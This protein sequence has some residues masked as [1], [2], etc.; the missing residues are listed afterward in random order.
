MNMSNDNPNDELA[1][2]LRRE[3]M[4]ERPA[5]S[6]ELH[7][8]ILQQLDNEPQREGPSLSIKLALFAYAAGTIF[9]AAGL[10]FYWASQRNADPTKDIANI[11]RPHSYPAPQSNGLDI[12]SLNTQLT[13]LLSSN[14]WP[15]LISIPFP[16]AS[17]D[18]V[19]SP[20]I[21]SEPPAP[22]AHQQGLPEILIA[23]L[24]EP[25]THADGSLAD[26]MPPQVRDLAGLVGFQ[27]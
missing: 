27:N 23:M 5:F 15:D 22:P 11:E 2:R 25:A 18:A 14:P 19:A 7:E 4:A 26:L 8:R 10:M 9:I 20:D 17:D 16:S 6:H 24:Q 1:N 12:A 3:A 21:Q 13:D